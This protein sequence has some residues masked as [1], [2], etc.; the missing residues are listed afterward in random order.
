[1]DFAGNR[2]WFFLISVVMVV[3]GLIFLVPP[4]SG[5]RAGIDFTGG[6]SMTLQFSEEIELRDL[7]S[8]MSLL[9]HEDAVVQNLGENTY[10]VRT[11]KLSDEEKANIVSKLNSEL[12]NSYSLIGSTNQQGEINI[13]SQE[14]LEFTINAHFGERNGELI[15]NQPKN[16]EDSLVTVPSGDLNL[17]LKDKTESDQNVLI[18]SAGAPVEGA[19]IT[20]GGVKVLAFDLVSPSVAQETVRNAFFAV[21]LAAVGIFLY[22]WWAFR[23]VPSPFRYGASAIIALI[24]D[25]VIV[26]GVFAALGTFVG[27]EVNL[28]FMIALL[29]VIGYS[30]NDTIVVF[31]RLRENVLVYPNRALWENVNVSISETISRS[32]NTSLTLLLTLLALMLFGGATIREFLLVLLVGVVVGTYSS[33]GVASQLL[34][35][36]EKGG[37]LRV[38]RRSA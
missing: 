28:M 7:R 5:L 21:L 12:D 11:K 18:V 35:V 13:P 27:M 16:E 37:I 24:H 9:D 34:V 36:W 4:I 8:Q 20:L 22:I 25:A 10:F 23:S 29:T 30:V 19:Q 33:I 15:V 14:K 26:I 6:S 17:V 31:D 3:S 1:M 2:R 38:F 32:L